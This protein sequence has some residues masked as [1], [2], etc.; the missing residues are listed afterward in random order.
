MPRLEMYKIALS[1][2]KRDPETLYNIAELARLSDPLLSK[3]YYEEVI[4]LSDERLGKKAEQRIRE[5][6][7]E[8]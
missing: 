3:Q 8:K 4:K 2:G 6:N 7:I 5:M 1:R